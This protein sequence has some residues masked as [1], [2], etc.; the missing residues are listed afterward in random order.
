VHVIGS[1][2]M[3]AALVAGVFV[4]FNGAPPEPAEA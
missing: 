2:V 4:V 1:S 3:I